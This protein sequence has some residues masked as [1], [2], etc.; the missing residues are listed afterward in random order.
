MAVDPTERYYPFDAGDGQ[1]VTEVDWSEMAQ[2]WQIS[3]VSGSAAGTGLKVT[4]TVATPFSVDMAPGAAFQ[5]GFFYYNSLVR[6]YVV[7]NWADGTGPRWDYVALK[8]DV[9]ANT[10]LPIIL[11]G[12]KN[13]FPSI[14]ADHL[15]VGSYAVTN[16]GVVTNFATDPR[17]FMSRGVMHYDSGVSAKPTAPSTDGRLL[18]DNTT[19]QFEISR[20]GAWV[21]YYPNAYKVPSVGAYRNAALNANAVAST[22]TAVAWDAETWEVNVPA[23]TLHS[24]SVNNTR[25]SAS[26]SGI[27]QFAYTIQMATNGAATRIQTQI[28]KNGSAN[29]RWNSM[30][31]IASGSGIIHQSAPVVM[32]AGEYVELMLSSNIASHAFNVGPTLVTA[33]WTLLTA[34]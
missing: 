22:L 14:P 7:P 30:E 32:T 23:D 15:V 12:T 11:Q 21:K 17:V 10:M 25:F 27:W 3:G 5:R 13:T 29:Q 9:A 34:T 16:A 2:Y 20:T 19:G 31:N 24:I 4:P 18:I 8:L 26:V 1:Y 33:Q 6:T 28:R